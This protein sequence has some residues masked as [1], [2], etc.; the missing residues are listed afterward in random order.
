MPRH[1]M[2]IYLTAS[3]Y[4]EVEKRARALGISRSEFIV[5]AIM[6]FVEP[7]SEPISQEG[8]LAKILSAI[9]RLEELMVAAEPHN[10]IHVK[11]EPSASAVTQELLL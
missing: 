6:S 10:R 4:R 9:N 3:Q 7:K 1:Q 2:S 5:T 8:Q 11:K